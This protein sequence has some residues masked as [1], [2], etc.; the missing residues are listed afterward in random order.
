MEEKIIG[1]LTSL[2]SKERIPIWKALK[3]LKAT[4]G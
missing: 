3:E 1:G 2:Y 4:A